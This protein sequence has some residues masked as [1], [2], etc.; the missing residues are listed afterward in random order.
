MK[1]VL[2]RVIPFDEKT[3]FGNLIF[4]LLGRNLDAN[5]KNSDDA[6]LVDFTALG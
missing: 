1:L 3:G 2:L 5:V 4:K 6:K